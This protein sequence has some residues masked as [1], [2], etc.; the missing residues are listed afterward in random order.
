M[1]KEILEAFEKTANIKFVESNGFGDIEIGTINTADGYEIH[2]ITQDVRNLNWE[3]EVFYYQPDFDTIMNHIN[4]CRTG[5]NEL[6]EVEIWD[7]EDYFDEYYIIDY[8][9]SELDED[10]LERL[11]LI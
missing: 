9:S 10:E 5:L 2:I 4:D 11:E 6:V 7:I 3:N 1:D 8:L